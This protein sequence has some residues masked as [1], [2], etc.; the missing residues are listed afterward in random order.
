MNTIEPN[1][2]SSICE[3]NP[4]AANLRAQANFFES[5]EL[6][7][8]LHDCN[9]EV[10]SMPIADHW[11][12]TLSGAIRLVELHCDSLRAAALQLDRQTFSGGAN[13]SAWW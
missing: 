13:G 8:T 2:S 12:H 10:W 7:Q 5:L 3:V 11:R 1:G 4:A 9:N 6:R